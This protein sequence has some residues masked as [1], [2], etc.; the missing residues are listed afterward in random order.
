MHVI[1]ILFVEGKC[2]VSPALKTFATQL[3]KLMC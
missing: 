2:L 3:V 1:I